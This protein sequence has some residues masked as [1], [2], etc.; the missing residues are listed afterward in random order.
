MLALSKMSNSPRAF[1]L[2]ELAVPQCNRSSVLVRVLA[3]GICQ[4]DIDLYL[5]NVKFDLELPRIPGHE[6]CGRV[7]EV[8]EDV[9]F[10]KV[11]DLVVAETAISTCHECR[12]CR[13]GQVNLCRSR[14][15]LGFG[16]DGTFAEYVVLPA[17]VVHAVPEGIAP[18]EA[19]L[20]EP[21]CVACNAV[22]EHSSFQPG[23]S[24][25]IIGPGTI[26]LLCL[27]VARQLI[28][29]EI[30]VVGSP[31]HLHRERV[32]SLMGGHLVTGFEDAVT[33]QGRLAPE[34]ASTVIDTVGSADTLGLALALARPGG[35][36]IQVGYTFDWS[37][38]ELRHY[39][40]KAI[41]WRFVFSHTKSSWETS[42]RLLKESRV[43]LASLIGETFPLR[44]FE[45]AFE[46][47]MRPGSMRVL[48]LP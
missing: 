22:V 16:V 10:P 34:G 45:S 25:V 14:K 43:N 9:T 47:A 27:Q 30:A 15:G 24:L 1:T 39:I 8:G 40:F 4:S 19:A 7:V 29:P 18:T 5:H 48:L 6:F 38:V 26:G 3:S 44:D 11:G 23:D 35:S 17:S 37:S 33:W 2:R 12:Y 42:M 32:V 46:E 28:G 21:L 41:T 20:V 13:A 36:I 31:R